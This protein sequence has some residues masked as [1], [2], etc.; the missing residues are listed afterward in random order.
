MQDL[1]L[2][3]PHLQS[4]D[5][6]TAGHAIA[7]ASWHQVDYIS[8]YRLLAALIETHFNNCDL[9][10]LLGT[11]STSKL[12]C[13]IAYRVCKPLRWCL[14]AFLC[15][16]ISLVHIMHVLCRKMGIALAVEV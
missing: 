5:L 10:W 9:V 2:L 4:H 3:A 1:E 14:S 7:L 16:F 13:T 6:A 15:K 8:M 11:I 12:C